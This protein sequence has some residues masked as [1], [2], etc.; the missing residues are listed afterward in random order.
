MSWDILPT[1]ICVHILKIRNNIRDNSANII[2]NAWR[3]YI[4]SDIIALDVLLEIEIDQYDNIM[5]S[6]PSTLNILKTSLT[7]CSGKFYLNTW[8][9]LAEKLYYSLKIN[10]YPEDEWLT[11]SAVNYRKIKIQYN[12]LL[13][14]FNFKLP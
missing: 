12:I 4:I 10:K 9:L 2:Q 13:E 8:K 5:V 14:K 11:P 7:I 1:D 6:I 3:K